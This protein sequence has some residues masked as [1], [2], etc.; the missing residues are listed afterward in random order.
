MSA[1]L[2]GKGPTSK[3]L[4]TIR[5]RSGPAFV[6]G[7]TGSHCDHGA[8]PSRN[9]IFRGPTRRSHSGA[10]LTRQVFAACSRS[11]LLNSTCTSFPASTSVCAETS[12]PTGFAVPNAG[13]IP[14]GSCVG[15]CARALAI[16]S[17]ATAVP[18][19]P[20]AVDVKN[21]LLVFITSLWRT[22]VPAHRAT[23]EK[24]VVDGYFA[25]P[26]PH[27]CITATRRGVEDKKPGGELHGE[28]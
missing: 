9:S 6:P 20:K 5:F 11:F 10:M 27:W 28:K 23:R 16:A 13:G 24:P 15:S 7:N 1:S 14:A 3:P 12:G 2:P 26:T 18:T 19:N 8:N 22:S 25:A 4:L 17:G 21:S